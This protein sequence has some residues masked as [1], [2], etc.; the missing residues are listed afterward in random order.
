[1]FELTCKAHGKISLSV[2]NVTGFTPLL[3]EKGTRVTTF[4][5]SIYKVNETYEEVAKL[6]GLR[7]GEEDGQAA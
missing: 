5:G 2:K 4:D 6:V 3:D 7:D 1:M